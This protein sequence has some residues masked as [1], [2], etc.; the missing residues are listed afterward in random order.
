MIEQKE[1]KYCLRCGRKLKNVDARLR[2]YGEVCWKKKQ[3]NN[4]RKL[5]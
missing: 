2:G 3:R 1:H 5:F 4:H